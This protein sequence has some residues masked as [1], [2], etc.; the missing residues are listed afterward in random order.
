MIMPAQIAI[1]AEDRSDA[2]TLAQLV[3][4]HLND[5]RLSIAK[6]GYGGCS[7]MVSKGARDIK[8][9]SELGVSRFIICHDSDDI[10]P[11]DVREKVMDK[12]V[13]PSGAKAGCCVVVPVQEIEAWIIA[14]NDAVTKVIPTFSFKSESSPEKISS[15][16]EWLV[17]KSKASNG[18]PLYSPVTFNESV[19]K[20][21]RLDVVAKKCP[22][23][24]NFV[25]CLSSIFKDES[26]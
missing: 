5:D 25:K 13:R 7:A 26:E 16:K 6:K 22:S 24:K 20:Y 19:A 18:K 14:D 2:E 3:K 11:A 1:L 21:L 12:I 23:F 17:K 9:W 10:S 4:R 15:P 8:A